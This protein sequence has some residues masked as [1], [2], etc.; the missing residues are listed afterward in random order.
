MGWIAR[1]LER[2]WHASAALPVR[3]VRGMRQC[4]KSSLLERLGPGR[5][6]VSLD[7]AVARDLANRDPALFLAQHAPPVTIDEGA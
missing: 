5:R 4:G 7:D 2:S 6:I 1:D 3:I